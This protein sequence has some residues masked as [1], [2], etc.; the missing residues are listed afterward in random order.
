MLMTSK[1]LKQ[2][3]INGNRILSKEIKY[4]KNGLKAFQNV[5]AMKDP[6]ALGTISV[7]YFIN[8]DLKLKHLPG[9]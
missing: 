2:N 8:C 7:N 6:T 5:V 1:D 4:L 9:S 3:T